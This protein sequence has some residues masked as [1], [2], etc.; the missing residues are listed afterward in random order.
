MG[1][2][3]MVLPSKVEACLPVVEAALQSDLAL[4]SGDGG[5]PGPGADLLG[6]A[7]E[8]EPDE[9]SALGRSWGG[10]M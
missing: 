1:S 8:Q 2:M 10:L 6:G 7:A 3:C 5:A 9:R 4:A